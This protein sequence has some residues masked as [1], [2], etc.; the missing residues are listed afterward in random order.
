MLVFLT[1]LPKKQ[2]LH[3]IF[4]ATVKLF[5]NYELLIRSKYQFIR[6]YF[7]GEKPL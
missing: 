4:L 1:M 5:F 2:L 3:C 6:L 7:R